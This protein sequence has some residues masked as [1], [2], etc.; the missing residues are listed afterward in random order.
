M[1]RNLKGETM[2]DSIFK[3]DESKD[4]EAEKVA[5][6]YTMIGKHEWLDEDGF[7]RLPEEKEDDPHAYAKSVTFGNDT[8]YMAKRGKHGKLFNPFGMYTEGTAANRSRHMG[9]PE[10]NFQKMNEK[11]FNFYINFLKTKNTAW[12]HNAERE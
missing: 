12:L 5:G 1:A 11:A 10:W 4:P 7:P 6:I 3:M 2:N 8:H 9:R